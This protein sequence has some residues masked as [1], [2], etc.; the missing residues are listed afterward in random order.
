MLLLLLLLLPFLPLLPQRNKLQNSTQAVQLD[1][2]EPLPAPLQ[3]PY[4]VILCSDVVYSPASV[5]PLLSTLDALTG[6]DS[7]VLYACEFREGAGLELLHELL[8]E[9]HLQ[10]Q[11]VSVPLGLKLQLSL[12]RKLR[13]TANILEHCCSAAEGLWAGC[14]HVSQRATQ[15]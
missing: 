8:P 10:E 5:R 15:Q 7:T 9:Y 14:M 13:Q 1:W 12:V 6:P 3:P 4:D 2:G 11:L